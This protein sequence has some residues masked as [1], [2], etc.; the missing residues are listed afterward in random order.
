MPA[1]VQL[2]VGVILVGMSVTYGCVLAWR[3]VRNAGRC[4]E[5]RAGYNQARLEQRDMDAWHEEILWKWRF[6]WL[7]GP[8]VIGWVII[9]S[10]LDRL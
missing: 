2:V 7:F 5:G 9:D 8:L 3:V 10:A 6:G 1:I 4:P